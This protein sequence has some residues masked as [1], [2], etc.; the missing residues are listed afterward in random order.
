MKLESEISR[1]FVVETENEKN[2]EYSQKRVLIT[3]AH[4]YVGT[5]VEQWLAR[6]PE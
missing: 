1:E 6:W 3:G 5:S 2:R 4:S